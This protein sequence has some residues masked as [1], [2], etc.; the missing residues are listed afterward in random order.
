MKTLLSMFILTALL[1]SACSAASGIEIKD[2]WARPVMKDGNGAVYFQLRNHAAGGDEL[3]GISSAAA[4][5]VE[6]HESMMEGDVMQMRPVG[7]LPI[8]GKASIEFGPGGYHVMLI[9]VKQ[10]LKAGD[11]LEITL[12]FRDHEDIAVTVPVQ[13]SQPGETISNH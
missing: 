6:M 3:T 9:G 8:G 2:P 10:E 12:H 13:E 7:S 1:I 5:A 4:Q 11:T